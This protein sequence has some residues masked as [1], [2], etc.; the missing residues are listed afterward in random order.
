[1]SYKNLK[2]FFEEQSRVH[3]WYW[4]KIIQK[5]E[6]DI[7]IYGRRSVAAVHNLKAGIKLSP[8]DFIWVRP[9]KSYASGTEKKLVRRK[10][11]RDLQFGQVI[12]KKDLL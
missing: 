10:T 1:M 11:A 6:R 7:N 5:C 3:V 8:S 9:R 12:K 4:K 2:I